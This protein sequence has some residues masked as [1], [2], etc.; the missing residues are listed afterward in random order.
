MQ[1]QRTKKA[2]M[3]EIF[4]PKGEEDSMESFE[5]IFS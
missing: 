5:K 2:Q 3:P 1:Q 4:K